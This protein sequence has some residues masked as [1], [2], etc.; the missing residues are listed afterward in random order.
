MPFFTNLFMSQFTQGIIPEGSNIGLA[1]ADT[2]GM[3]AFFFS[4][5]HYQK[6]M[7]QYFTQMMSANQYGE[8]VKRLSWNGNAVNGIHELHR[9]SA[10]SDRE[11]VPP[12][13]AFQSGCRDL[14]D[15]LSKS[16]TS[17]DNTGGWRKDVNAT[18][19][20]G[21]TP[22]HYAVQTGQNTRITKLAGIR[23]RY[24]CGSL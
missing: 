21:Y 5:A 8:A 12:S 14:R 3:A 6:V 4:P 15:T 22:L 7:Q 9:A 13:A 20:D 17:Q 19:K 16:Q 18:D 24:I 23:Q 1:A 10:S 11:L 2:T